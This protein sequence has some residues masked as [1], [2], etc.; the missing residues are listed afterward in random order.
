M[1]FVTSLD[2]NE[3]T[4]LVPILSNTRKHWALNK[5]SFIYCYTL[6]THDEFI[7]GINHND[8]VLGN[9]PNLTMP[10]Y[11]YNSKY[12]DFKGIEAKVLIWLQN[13]ELQKH[14]FPNIV[15]VDCFPIM[16]LLPHVRSIKDE[17]I[18]AYNKFSQKTALQEYSSLQQNLSTIEKNGLFTNDGYEYCEYNLFT[19][20]GRP[21]NHFNQI[22]YAALNKN[23]NSRSRF[24]SRFGVD[25]ILMEF[26]LKAFHIYL[27][28]N[29]TG[30]VWPVDDIYAYFGTFYKDGV[31]SKEETFKQLY[32][33]ISDEYLHI[34]FF[35][36]VKHLTKNLYQRYKNNALKT[37][38]FDREMNIPV[39]TDVKVLNY[40][41]QSL[42]TEFNASFISKINDYLYTRN[43]KLILYTYDSF[44]ID[45][46]KADGPACFTALKDIFKDVPHRLKVG[47]NYNMLIEC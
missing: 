36:K 39:L 12:L 29:L 30:Y 4:L 1:K 43:S 44:L 8:T 20:T 9:F 38:L 15:N 3:E 7:I 17:F 33:G 25:G 41:L 21:S 13:K 27:L 46:S 42:E 22:S 11:I 35:E 19:L 28:S 10:C 2:I 6:Q 31:S 32:G 37:V 16:K 45:F 23:D 24:K 26:D 18:L 34:D 5:V 47:K 40:I 14:Q